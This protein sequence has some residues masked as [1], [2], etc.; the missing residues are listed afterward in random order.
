MIAAWIGARLVP[1]G[2]GVAIV[3]ALVAFDRVR[4][5]NAETRGHNTA[6][7]KIEAQTNATVSLSNKAG[8]AS[9]NPSSGGVRDPYTVD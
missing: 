2:A 6:V 3:L 4:I 9:R 1:I 8:A 7:A 5:W